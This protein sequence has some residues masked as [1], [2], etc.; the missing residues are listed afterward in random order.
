MPSK[1]CYS[2]SS[3]FSFCIN[4][5]V[6]QRTEVP[7]SGNHRRSTGLSIGASRLLKNSRVDSLRIAEC[8]FGNVILG[9]LFWECYFGN[10]ILGMLFWRFW[11]LGGALPIGVTEGRI[12]AARTHFGRDSCSPNRQ[13]TQIA[14]PNQVVSGGREGK[15]PSEF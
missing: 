8:Y 15:Y 6:T 5:S 1:G 9:M 14:H 10:V 4:A 3:L 13:S 12:L 2:L 7:P 11:E